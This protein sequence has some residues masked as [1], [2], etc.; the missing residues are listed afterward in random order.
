MCA[1]KPAPET[2]YEDDAVRISKLGTGRGRLV[3]CLSGV[4]MGNV[5]VQREEFVGASLEGGGSTALYFFDKLRSW[6]NGEGIV[7]RFSEVAGR[8]IETGGYGRTIAVGN[9]M[10]G[11]GAVLM[12]SVVPLDVAIA[13]SP[14]YSVDRRILP[15]ERRWRSHIDAIETFRFP[16]LGP[17]FNAT[18]RYYVLHGHKGEDWRHI[19]RFP[20]APNMRHMVFRGSGHNIAA[21]LK[22]RDLLRPMM[23]AMMDADESRLNELTAGLTVPPHGFPRSLAGL[24]HRL[25][26]DGPWF[27]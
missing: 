13:I 23:R 10:G 1:H 2:V 8:E 3:L 25:L 6:F 27:R 12:S 5:P 16:D 21:H 18:T 9:S 14:Q 24:A 11:F 19:R 26:P 7:E 15:H 17:H 20:A 22:A 4:G